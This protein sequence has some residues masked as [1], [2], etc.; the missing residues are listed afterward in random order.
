DS[1]KE[2]AGK[3]DRDSLRIKEL[4]SLPFKPMSLEEFWKAVRESDEKYR[5]DFTK[6]YST[7]N[8]EGRRVKK[9]RAPLAPKEN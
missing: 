5:K 3:V 2:P 8:F 1:G 4:T 6:S 7:V 9:E